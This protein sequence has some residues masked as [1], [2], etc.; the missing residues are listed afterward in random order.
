[1]LSE[2]QETRVDLSGIQERDA[3]AK[4]SLSTDEI[5]ERILAAITEHR[6]Q[7]GTQLI[8]DRLAKIF[9][10]SRTKIREAT[11]RLVHNHIA[12]NIPNRGA[13]VASPTAQEARE[14]FAARRLIEPELMRLVA[15]SATTKQIAQLRSHLAKETAARAKNSYAI[16]PLSGEFHLLVAEMAG[17]SFLTRALRDLE[18][19][20]CLIIVLYDTHGAQG[21]PYDDH[22]HLVDAIEAH[23]P[24]RAAKL[25]LEHIDH[26]EQS[27]NLDPT[28]DKRIALEDAFR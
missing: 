26:I 18:S 5:Y 24:E 21:C 3:K 6:L 9:D 17:N 1:M 19:I 4:A 23:D 22:A 11:V 8:E 12:V 15:R 10:V 25:M 7:P 13:F 16:I 27:L 28:S 20:T 14:I 2:Q